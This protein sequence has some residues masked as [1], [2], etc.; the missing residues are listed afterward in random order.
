M[1]LTGE[2]RCFLWTRY[3]RVGVNGVSSLDFVGNETQASSKFLTQERKK[4]SKGYTEIKMSLGSSSKPVEPIV[5]VAKEE[6]FLP[7]KLDSNVQDFVKL[8]F[9]QKLMEASVVNIGYDVKK[10]PL[11]ELQKETVIKGYQI[12]KNIEAVLQGTSK[13]SLADLSSQFY[14]NIPHNFGMKNMSLF[15][16]NSIEKLKEKLDLI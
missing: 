12:L 13:A 7:S 11:G 9:N 2:P 6:D 8:I 3:G 14:T 10:M 15:I 1:Q 4:K 5:T 16:I